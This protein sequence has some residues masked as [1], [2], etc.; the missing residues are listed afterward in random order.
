VL[1][2]KENDAAAKTFR[3]ES[4][5][6]VSLEKLIEPDYAIPEPQTAEEVIGY[7]AR[8]IAQDV[9]YAKH[10]NG[11]SSVP[12]V[13]QAPLFRRRLVFARLIRNVDILREP[14]WSYRRR[15]TVI[16]QS[17]RRWGTPRHVVEEKIRRWSAAS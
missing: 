6:L 12:P 11:K 4:Y 10:R 8:R 7:Y 14:G 13:E 3:Y 1:P 5:D 2:C 9:K 15:E 17:R 16:E